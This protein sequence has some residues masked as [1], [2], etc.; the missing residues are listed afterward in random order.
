M[1]VDNRSCLYKQL[2]HEGL[3]DLLIKASDVD[4]GIWNN[5]A[6]DSSEGHDPIT[7]K[8]HSSK[9]NLVTFIKNASQRLPKS[10]D[11]IILASCLVSFAPIGAKFVCGNLL[12]FAAKRPITAKFDE[13]DKK[14]LRNVT[15]ILMKVKF[16]GA[17]IRRFQIVELCNN[18]SI[19]QVAC[20]N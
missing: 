12:W 2:P 10:P 1:D 20:L 7:Q 19:C 14:F 8:S 17:G 15:C 11:L 16:L 13:C 4:G 3:V 5:K 18:V 9:R 6:I